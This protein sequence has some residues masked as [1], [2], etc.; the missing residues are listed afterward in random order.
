MA[1]FTKRQIIQAALTDIGLPFYVYDIQ[2]EQYTAALWRLNLMMAEW[3]GQGVRMGYPIPTNVGDDNL[4]DASNLPDV[5]TKAVILHL[6]IEL[7]PSYGKV[8]APETKMMAK[9]AYAALLRFAAMPNQ[10]QWPSTLPYGAGNKPF[11]WNNQQF[12]GS[13][14]DQDQPDPENDMT[15]TPVFADPNK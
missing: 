10:Y 8:A 15:F 3:N 9:R 11:R 6:A 4:D 14:V 5:V 13:P 2:P 12:V 1:G 7:A